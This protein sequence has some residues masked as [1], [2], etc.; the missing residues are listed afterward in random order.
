M[1]LLLIAKDKT[2]RISVLEAAPEPVSEY[3]KKDYV[4]KFGLFWDVITVTRFAPDVFKAVS[5]R[6]EISQ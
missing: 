2:G 4:E 1:K 3:M 5:E 6:L